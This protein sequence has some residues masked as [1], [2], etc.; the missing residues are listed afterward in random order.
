[1][2]YK[3]FLYIKEYK[4]VYYIEYIREFLQKTEKHRLIRFNYVH[5]THSSFLSRYFAKRHYGEVT[6]KRKLE[7]HSRGLQVGVAPFLYQVKLSV[8]FYYD[9]EFHVWEID[10]VETD[11]IE[12]IEILIRRMILY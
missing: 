6:I 11:W 1:M 8:T 7:I 2:F 3:R 10:S 5:F 4:I 12:R 9:K